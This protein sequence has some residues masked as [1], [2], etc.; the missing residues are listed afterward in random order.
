MATRQKPMYFELLKTAHH[1]PKV[2]VSVRLGK[3]GPNGEARGQKGNSRQ[4][5]CAASHFK[6]G[7]FGSFWG[8]TRACVVL[9]VALH[10]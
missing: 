3:G 1:Y 5:C 9:V 2:W 6:L 4:S 7:G 8:L 10:F